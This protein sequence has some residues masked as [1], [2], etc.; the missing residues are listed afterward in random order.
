MIEVNPR[1]SRTVPYLSKSLGIPLAKI[2][3]KS[4]LGVPL[5]KQGIFNVKKPRHYFMK[6]P[7]FSEVLSG[8]NINYGPEML[9]TGEKMLIGRSF[10]NL[11]EKSKNSLVDP[12]SLQEIALA[13]N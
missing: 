13:L 1:A 2:A 5:N 12:L 11:I 8:D 9:S 3:T 4:I 7:V 10:D 6:I